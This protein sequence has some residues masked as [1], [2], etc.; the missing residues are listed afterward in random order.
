MTGIDTAF[1]IDL[2]ILESPRHAAA[3]EA[4]NRWR[5][6]KNSILVIYS[7]IFNEFLHV[8]TD[9]RRF[10]NPVPME[11]AIERCWYWIDHSRVRVVYADDDSLKRQLLWMSMHNLGRKRINDTT[12]A[13]A[14]A[15]A[16]VSKIITA[17]PDDFEIL[18]TFELITYGEKL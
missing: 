4:F 17:N 3:V 12:M 9:P 11:T 14:Y 5:N 15:Q 2:E 18:N 8:V 6:E 10:T 7:N 1:L 16:G 13:A